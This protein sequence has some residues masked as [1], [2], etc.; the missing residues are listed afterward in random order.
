MKS[1]A[2][3]MS[4]GM[5]LAS[6]LAGLAQS[7]RPQQWTK[8]GFIFLAP[9]FAHQ[10]HHR[11]VLAET[12]A[13]FALFCTLSGAV[14]VLNDVI[15]LPRDAAHPEKR[16]RPIAS[17]RVPPAVA[18]VFAFL[19][20]AAAVGG[21][22]LLSLS[23][24][25]T[26]VGYLANNLVYSF[27]IKHIAI[28]DV[29]SVAAG[30]LLRAVAG[31][32]AVRVPISYW[33]L[34]CMTMLALFLALCKRRQELTLLE[35]D[36]ANHRASLREYTLQFLDHMIT[37]VAASTLMAYS[38]YALSP[39]VRE[40]LGTPYLGLTIPFVVYGMFRYLYLVHMKG[41]G[42]NPSRL[43]LEDRPTQLNLLLWGGT[44][45]LMIYWR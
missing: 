19:L 36:A 23:F 42:G 37:V 40:K 24:G 3:P 33:L 34:L 29:M 10:L 12:L 35:G 21:S 31:G 7:L 1:E 15:D 6:V 41:E 20:A 26:A 18:V 9:L 39:D 4:K 27:W 32:F 45:L 38:L 22:F 44:A 43:L 25:W 11:Q 16:H 2:V 5:Q 17:G 8:N 14:Y 30:F 28:L 13:A